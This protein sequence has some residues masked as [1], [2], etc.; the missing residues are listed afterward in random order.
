MRKE[1]QVATL[2]LCSILLLQ[3][4]SSAYYLYPRGNCENICEGDYQVCVSI[5]NREKSIGDVRSQEL[6]VAQKKRCRDRC[7]QDKRDLEFKIMAEDEAID[8]DDFY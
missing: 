6:C 4:T 2:V 3:S 1:I 5:A 7:N 8:Y